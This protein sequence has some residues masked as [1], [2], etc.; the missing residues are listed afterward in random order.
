MPRVAEFIYI[1]GENKKSVSSVGIKIKFTIPAEDNLLLSPSIIIIII[2]SLIVS[3][4]IIFK[5]ETY[6]TKKN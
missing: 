4:F 1:E 2:V 3:I 5:L 6:E